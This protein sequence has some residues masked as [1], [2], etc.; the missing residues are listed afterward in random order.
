MLCRSVVAVHSPAADVQTVTTPAVPVFRKGF[1]RGSAQK[2]ADEAA[3]IAGGVQAPWTSKRG[4]HLDAQ[5]GR[6]EEKGTIRPSAAAWADMRGV[7]LESRRKVWTRIL[8][9]SDRY[10]GENTSR[11][12]KE[13]DRGMDQMLLY[14]NRLRAGE[15]RLLDQFIRRFAPS[16]A[17]TP[18]MKRL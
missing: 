4:P 11:R 12:R 6:P 5:A 2:Q 7:M 18:S 14:W 13:I 16:S 17:S 15:S 3:A 9:M 1:S 10:C 8:R